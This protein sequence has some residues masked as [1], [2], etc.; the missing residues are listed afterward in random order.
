MSR[1]DHNAPHHHQG[2]PEREFPTPSSLR[3]PATGVY[4]T[5][6][7]TRWFMQ[8]V[9][10]VLGT[11]DLRGA[12]TQTDGSRTRVEVRPLP[13][14]LRDLDKLRVGGEGRAAGPTLADALQRTH[15]D[16]FLVLH[17]GTIVSEQYF[18]GMRPETPHMWQSVSK[19]LMSCVAGNLVEAGL[20]DLD[21]RVAAYVPALVGS[22][23]GDALV[24][25]LLDM[26]VGIDYS[27]DYADL[28]S[29]VNEL[30]RLYGLRAPREPGQPGSTYEYACAVRKRG[31]H[32]RDFD[33]VSLNVNVLAWVM[34][35]ATGRWL[36]ELIRDEVWAKLGGEHDAYIGLDVAG[37]AQAESAVCS[38]L[39]DLARLGLA[40][41]HG[42]RLDDHQVVPAAW[43]AAIERGGDEEAFAAHDE[44]G[45]MP[46]GSY[47]RG[48]WISRALDHVALMGLGIYGQMVYANPQADLVVAKFSTQPLADD[49]DAFRLE[50]A[51]AERLAE[52]LG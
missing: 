29:D 21:E 49:M 27:E 13:V 8:H 22:A 24:R 40:L 6:E 48:F 28:D 50:F 9:R 11:A 43:V 3:I 39:R 31:V 5:Q 2:S 35:R 47:K 42:G 17:Q 15:T 38:S 37:S 30:D 16:A 34:E 23:Y 45:V 52:K 25:H 7:S 26:Q 46:G 44:A 14:A 33:Y 51:L 12:S 20:L 10:E 4:R 19:S 36:P 32:G 1:T 18:H 41:A